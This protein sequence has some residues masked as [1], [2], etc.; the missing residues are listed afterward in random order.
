MGLFECLSET[1]LKGEDLNFDNL[2]PQ[3][4]RVLFT[5][6]GRSDEEIA[7]L[8]NVK[9][10][11]VSYRRRKHGISIRSLIVEDLLCN[12]SEKAKAV[13]AQVRDGLFTKENVSTISKA[14]TNFAFREGPVED[15]HS[16]G[17]L[18]Q[19]DMKALGKFMVN[20]LAYVFQLLIEERWAEFAFLI[21]DNRT[22]S[23]HWD[24]A[25][26][27]DGHMRMLIEMKMNDLRNK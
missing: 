23:N 17:Q 9:K 8:F 22:F 25:D 2:S 26:P 24:E 12:K 10:S 6:E 4:L 19:S 7:S 11:K 14:I 21:H 18:T 15:I 1:K 3:H 20:R 27:D 5:E 13:N 16:K